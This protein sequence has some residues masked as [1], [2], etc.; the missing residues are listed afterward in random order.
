[1]VF[2]VDASDVDRLPEANKALNTLLSCEELQ[3]VP[4]LIL[5][6]KVDNGNAVSEE[7]LRGQLGLHQTYGKETKGGPG[8]DIRPTEV[9]MCSILKK[10]GY[11]DGFN[12]LSQFL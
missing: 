6:N 5:G 4:F 1:M 11:S 8:G 3:S 2:I 12:W 10:Q 7:N 9:Y